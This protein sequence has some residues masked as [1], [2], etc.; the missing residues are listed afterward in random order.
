MQP[1]ATQRPGA[2]LGVLPVAGH[3]AVAPDQH[4]ADRARG[5]RPVVLVGDPDLDH[6]L[7]AA[8]RAQ[9]LA[10]ARVAGIGVRALVSAVMHIGLSP[11][12]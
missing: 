7:R 8:D 12:P 10:V 11:W 3:H 5:Q 4:L 6:E 9:P 2:G 1:A